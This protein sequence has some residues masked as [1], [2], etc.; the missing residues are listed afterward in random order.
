LSFSN[1]LSLRLKKA[2]GRYLLKALGQ[3]PNDALLNR[4]LGIRH[5]WN[6]DPVVRDFIWTY[7]PI[8][9]L[10][11]SLNPQTAQFYLQPVLSRINQAKLAEVPM[12]MEFTVKCLLKG[13]DASQLQ[14][15]M[16]RL[17]S[18]A[19]QLSFEPLVR[20]AWEQISY[21]FNQIRGPGLIQFP[22]RVHHSDFV[23]NRPGD[24]HIYDQQKAPDYCPDLEHLVDQLLLD[25]RWQ[26]CELDLDFAGCV[27]YRQIPYWLY[28]MTEWRASDRSTR[29]VL[30]CKN[31]EQLMRVPTSYN[32]FA[33][34][35][36][37]ELFSVDILGKICRDYWWSPIPETKPEPE[38]EVANS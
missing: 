5:H 34:D 32:A 7:S 18:L 1:Q 15:N 33:D 29:Q 16:F 37:R 35:H 36:Q 10:Y 22:S 23:A 11:L 9:D 27:E 38:P 25:D 8:E 19:R 31:D 20:Y 24:W 30:I 21:R 26:K 4:F 12:L 13:A 17:Y 6:P 2:P 3:R 14:P 28:R